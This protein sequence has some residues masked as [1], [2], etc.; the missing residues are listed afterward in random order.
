MQVP[1]RCPSNAPIWSIHADP[2]LVRI[3]VCTLNDLG[4]GLVGG[5]SLCILMHSS[6]AQLRSCRRHFSSFHY[7]W[8]RPPFGYSSTT[9]LCRNGTCAQTFAPSTSSYS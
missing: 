6:Q 3:L 9:H 8:M 7:A 5:K 2:Y 1:L 4:D